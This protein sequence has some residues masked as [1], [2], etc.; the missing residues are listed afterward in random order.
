MIVSF[1]EYGVVNN[2]TTLLLSILAL[3]IGIIFGISIGLYVKK[4]S[5]EQKK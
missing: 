2:A 1:I 3:I 4:E 5:S